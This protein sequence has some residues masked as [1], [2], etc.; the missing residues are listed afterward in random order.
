MIPL[1]ATVE[2]PRSFGGGFDPQV[3]RSH[4]R[5]NVGGVAFFFPRSGERGYGFQTVFWPLRLARGSDPRLG[6]ACSHAVGVAAKD[7]L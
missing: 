7:R 4:V 1:R 6:S 2:E 3:S 5:Q